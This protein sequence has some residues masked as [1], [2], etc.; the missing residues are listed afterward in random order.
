MQKLQFINKLQVYLLLI[1]ILKLNYHYTDS[2]QLFSIDRAFISVM[3]LKCWITIMMD[4][5]GRER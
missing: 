5:G 3:V 1:N 4:C 2:D